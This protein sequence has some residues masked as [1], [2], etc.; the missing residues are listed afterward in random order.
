MK[1]FD[2]HHPAKLLPK[3]IYNLTY[4]RR[5][6]VRKGHAA[7]VACV[8]QLRD[9]G[10]VHKPFVNQQRRLVGLV[11][12]TPTA[13][14]LLLRFPTVLSMDC[15]YNTN[16]HGMLMLHVAGFPSTK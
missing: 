11:Y 9:N 8:L 2:K 13:R 16:Q 5:A 3:D 7:T 1:S 6:G 4:T 15:I 12:T 10:E 14:A